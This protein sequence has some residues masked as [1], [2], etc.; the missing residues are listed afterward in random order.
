MSS[1]VILIY[2]LLATLAFVAKAN[3]AV[4]VPSRSHDCGQLEAKRKAAGHVEFV[5]VVVVPYNP[6]TAP[7][8]ITP[9][10]A[11]AASNVS[12]RILELSAKTEVLADV[13]FRP[14]TDSENKACCS[15]D[16]TCIRIK[17]ISSQTK[18]HERPQF[19]FLVGK[20]K[21]EIAQVL[22]LAQGE[23]LDRLKPAD[24]LCS[25][26]GLVTVPLKLDFGMLSKQVTKRDAVIYP[27]RYI[28]SV[29]QRR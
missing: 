19:C 22:V 15:A 1:R 10:A 20:M 26:I 28:N 6:A 14:G 3:V 18:Q 9:I 12:W 25:S 11:V 5:Q 27:V 21:E 23:Q 17:G 13:V 7:N 29:K 4:S 2:T 24:G 16:S 8:R